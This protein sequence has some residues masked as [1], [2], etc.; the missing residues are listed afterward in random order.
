MYPK[1]GRELTQECSSTKAICAAGNDVY[2]AV[3][4]PNGNPSR[5]LNRL[6]SNP[7]TDQYDENG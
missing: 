6:G 5:R 1:T 7:N 3:L 2:A 4:E